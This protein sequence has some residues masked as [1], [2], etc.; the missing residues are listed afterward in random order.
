MRIRL[1]VDIIRLSLFS[2]FHIFAFNCQIGPHRLVVVR[3][4]SSFPFLLFSPPYLLVFVLRFSLLLILLGKL[5]Y[6][7][8]CAG[9]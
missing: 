8:L 6:I 1:G 2:L 7:T 4:F 3:G 5:G 9:C